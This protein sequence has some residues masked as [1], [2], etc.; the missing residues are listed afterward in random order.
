[1]TDLEKTIKRLR[2]MKQ[3]KSLPIEEIEKKAK[4]LIEKKE[5]KS[6]FASSLLDDEIE[7]AISLYNKFLIESSFES[8]AEKSSLI[9]LI[10]LMIVR[11]RLLK[12]IKSDAIKTPGANSLSSTDSIM[13][14]DEQI[15]KLMDKLGMLKKE[16]DQN[17]ATKVI[18]DL[19]L[20]FHKWINMPENR[21]NYT[22]QCFNCGQ[23]I[24]IRRRL[25]K[26]K[27]E[28]KEHPWF[29]EGGLLFNKEIFK[30]L[31]EKKISEEQA[32]R[33]LDCAV[34]YLKWI[35]EHYP[36]EEDNQENE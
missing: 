16:G 23:S 29:I 19:K 14:L 10:T 18:E 6:Q 12:S 33:Y 3:N 15:D 4:L 36:M 35:I 7:N 13:D 9:R 26:E 24:L 21:S 25:D 22:L 28:I 32:A 8:L 2:N 31:K 30:D 20:R 5:L 11:E 34:D 1:M 17:D 27:D